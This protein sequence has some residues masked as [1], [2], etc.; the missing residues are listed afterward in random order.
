MKPIS[1]NYAVGLFSLAAGI[2]LGSSPLCAAERPDLLIADFE[3]ESYGEWKATGEAFGDGPARGTLPGQMHVEGFLG[4]GLVNSF[5]GGDRT[6]GT[7]TSPPIALSRKYLCFLVGGGKHA[8]KTCINLLVDGRVVRTATGPNDQG[9]GS[10]RLEWHTWDIADLAGATAV[11]EIV[12][13]ATGGWGHVNVDHIVQSDRRRGLAPFSRDLA[14]DKPL[15]LLPVKTKAPKRRMQLVVAGRTVREFDIELAEGGLGGAVDFWAVVDLAAWRAAPG[16]ILTVKV[17]LPSESKALDAVRLADRPPDEDRPYA[18][19][20]RPQF[21][22]TSRRGWLNDPNG[23]VHHAG[24]WHL[25]YQHNPYGWSWGNM[26]WGHAESVDLIR[27]RELP[28][29]LYPPRHGDWCF[30]GS[31]VVDRENAAGWGRGGEEVLVAAF[32]STGRGECIVYSRDRGRTWTEYE[33]N[34]VVRHNGRDPRLLWYAPGKHWVMAVYTEDG[35]R[36][37]AF[38]RSGNL[39]EWTY[40]SRIEGFFECPDLFELPLQGEAKAPTESRWILYAA[41]GNYLVGRFDGKEFVKES[42]KHELWHGNFYAAQTFS[43]APDGRRVQ[44]GWA[45]GA[46]FPD[47]PFNQQMTVPVELTLRRTPDGPRMHAVPVRELATLR[48]KEHVWRDV[49]LV[50]GENPLAHLRG[51]LFELAAEFEPSGAEAF[52]LTLRGVPVTCD[53]KKGTLSCRGIAA[54]LPREDGRVRLR[55]LLDRGSIEV[56]AGDGRVALS[57]AVLPPESDRSIAV[58]GRGGPVKLRRLEVYELQSAW[59]R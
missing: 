31:A 55:A 58:W 44:I 43:D 6:T 4:K 51:E 16:A 15:L 19:S 9:G 8:G 54:P 5:R 45:R 32:T 11:I 10:E 7:L 50:P 1:T 24:R 39:K 59:V 33:K 34:P 22:F 27:W 13:A 56:F 48:T 29:A 57:V 37:I 53:A 36:A 28:I 25:F 2:A 35:G 20:R 23:L 3:Q 40:S 14:I 41:D 52:G 49:E 42:G 38:Y 30:S 46:D 17:D 47:M 12:D 21:H 18:E 26:H